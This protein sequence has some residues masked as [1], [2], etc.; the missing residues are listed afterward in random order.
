[1]IWWSLFIEIN[2]TLKICVCVCEHART[3]LCTLAWSCMLMSMCMGMHALAHCV[4]IMLWLPCLRLDWILSN[5]NSLILPNFLYLFFIS[6]AINFN[7]GVKY[8]NK[9]LKAKVY[10]HYLWWW[11]YFSTL[12]KEVG[13]LHRPC[14]SVNIM[15]LQVLLTK[16]KLGLVSFNHLYVTLANYFNCLSVTFS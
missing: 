6:Q 8:K 11:V 1:M 2:S 14:Q 12:E 3:C 10:T 9:V 16:G 15:T 4:T 13:T 7:F 5:I